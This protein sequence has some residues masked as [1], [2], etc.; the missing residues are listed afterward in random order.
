MRYWPEP[1][2][3]Y[4]SLK[5]DIQSF[6]KDLNGTS[7]KGINKEKL[8]ELLN[9][10]KNLNR[11]FNNNNTK[12]QK[13]GKYVKIMNKIKTNPKS[14]GAYTEAEKFLVFMFSVD[15]NFEAAKIHGA[16]NTTEEIKLEMEKH[17]GLYDSKLIIIEN[18]FIKN[19]LSEKT[20]NKINEEIEKRAFK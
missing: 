1:Y 20:R 16:Y 6:Y 4:T 11:F 2:Q 19:F 18:F 5:S 10:S 17:F 8:I 15:P 14:F 13:H 3:Y 9:N 7:F 12:I